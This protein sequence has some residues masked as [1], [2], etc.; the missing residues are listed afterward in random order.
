[1]FTTTRGNSH[2]RCGPFI[3]SYILARCDADGGNVYLISQNGE[4]DFVPSLMEDG[5]VIYSRWEYTDKAL[6]RVQSLWTVNPD[7]T[8]VSVFWGNQSVW[9]DHVGQPQQIPGTQKV[10]F[11]GVGASRLVVRFDR[12]PG[13]LRRHELPA[14]TDQGHP[15][16]ALARG[17]QRPRGSRPLRRYHAAGRLHGLQHAVPVIGVRFPGLGAR[18]EANRFRLYLMD[19]DGNRELIYEGAH[20]ILHAMPI[21]PRPLPAIR[22]DTVAW[23]GTGPNRQPPQPGIFFSGDVYD[24]VPDLPRG[25]VKYLRVFQQDHKTYTTWEKTYRHSGPAVSIIQEEAVKRILGVAP[26]EADGSV[27]FEVPPGRVAVLPAAGR[28]LPLP[29]DHAQ[30]FGP[31]A[32]RSRAAAS[33]ATNCTAPRR[34][35]GKG[36]PC[37][38][39]PAT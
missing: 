8:H 28:G 38:V 25:S 10:M 22:A 5:R 39:R 12:H 4:P 37:F 24:G 34:R 17:R 31:D 20:N 14:R 3:Y 9:P 11:C 35:C 2:V 23:P 6:W 7:G 32:R 16:A 27:H 18:S 13:P 29:A 26:V 30:L 21:R 15:R 1:M 36:W 33:A 19:V